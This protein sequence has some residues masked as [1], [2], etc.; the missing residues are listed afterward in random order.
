MPD[1]EIATIENEQMM[2]LEQERLAS[3]RQEEETAKGKQQSKTQQSINSGEAIILLAATGFIEIIQWALDL[4][5][6]V[7]W[8]V[9]GG[10]SILVA[11]ALFIWATGK[12][13]QGA[14]KSWYKVIWLGAFGGALP[15]IP[16]Q[17]GAIIYLLIQDRKLLGKIGG[18]LGE[19]TEK[20]ATKIK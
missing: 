6:Y 11:M 10:I 7:G 12:V 3:E 19:E 17:L 9:N 8:V 16:G 1:D 18:K 2:R 13:A 15:V 20:L 4:I 5:P 14:P